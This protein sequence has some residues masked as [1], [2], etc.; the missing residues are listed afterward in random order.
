MRVLLAIG[1]DSYDHAN[2][3][4]GAERDAQ[5]MYDLL[6]RTEVG[7]YDAN[8]S[9]ILL[10]PTYSDVREAL[11]EALFT[12]PPSDTFTFFFAGHGSVSAGAFYMWL[13]DSTQKGLSMSALSLADMFRSINEAAPLQSNIIIDACESGGLIE[14]LGALLKPGLLGNVGS[15]GL[16]LLATA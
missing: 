8:R 12:E 7:E 4:H 6:I 3:L 14:D 9:R 11:K 16:T 2:L 5:R 10:S 15:P 1:C 13:R